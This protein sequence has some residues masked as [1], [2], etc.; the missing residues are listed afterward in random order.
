MTAKVHAF[1]DDELVLKK[2]VEHVPRVGDTVRF[3][4]DRFAVVTEVVW[5][6]DEASTEGQRAN[7]R[8]VTFAGEK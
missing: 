2:R 6:F 4:A 7:I 3:G 1:L 5:C 8:C